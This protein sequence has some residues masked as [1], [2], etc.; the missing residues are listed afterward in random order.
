MRISRTIETR[1]PLA[2]VFPYLADFRS[3]NDWDPG[4]VR[5]TRTSGDG[6]VGTV[7]RNVS[8]FM[9]RETELDYTVIELAEGERLALRGVNET[10]EAVDTMRLSAT[11]DGGTRVEYDAEFRFKGMVGRV[12]PLLSPLLW[13]AFKRLGDEAEKGMT[14]SLDKLA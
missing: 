14:T 3:T 9:G 6:G 2:K 13:V 1:T 5:T 4:T 8:R 10:V 11:A 12:A 7:Y